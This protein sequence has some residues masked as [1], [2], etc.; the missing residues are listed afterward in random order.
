MRRKRS[1]FWFGVVLSVDCLS[2][3]SP[4]GQEAPAP[5]DAAVGQMVADVAKDRLAET[6]AGLAS[7]RTRFS[8]TSGCHAAGTSIYNYLSRLGLAVEYDV[9]R[10][11][12][13]RVVGGGEGRNVVATLP[14]IGGS[15]GI[16]LV[17]AHYDSF[18]TNEFRT[19]PGA[20]DNASG[21]AAVLEIARILSQHRF[22]RT[23]RFVA[24]DAEEMGTFGSEHL[25]AAAKSRRDAIVAMLNLDMVGF[26]RGKKSALAVV[27]ERADEWLADRFIQ[28][29]NRYGIPIRVV[30]RVN[31]RW[32]RSNQLS[33][34]AA[35][36]PALA[37][38]E[39]TPDDNPHYHHPSDTADTLDM[40]F[41]TAA[42][43]ATL[44]T[45][46]TLA[47]P[48]PPPE[49]RPGARQ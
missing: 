18:S 23:I 2:L 6:T 11:T 47:G 31:A 42:T 7:V 46:A 43:R 33:F 38:S 24:F 5:P 8:P 13:P 12:S 14:G 27:P 32:A 48:Q 44:A 45:L 21:T 39:D 26:K 15:E 28:E 3:A 35:G 17:G 1:V 30:K 37:V 20:D 10:Y 41:L 9:F 40:D 19:A 49:R 22:T 29:A 16:L 25:A 34:R 4:F 36:Y